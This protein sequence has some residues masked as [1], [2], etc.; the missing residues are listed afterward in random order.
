MKIILSDT[1]HS[2]IKAWQLYFKDCQ[3]VEIFAGSIFETGCNAIVSPANS[4]GFMDGGL[5]LAISNYLG[6]HVQAILQAKIKQKYHGELL[7]GQAEIVETGHPK[8]PYLISAPT[9]RVPLILN[10]TVNVY[11]AMRAVLL[12]I[13]YCKLDNGTPVKEVVRAVS[14]SG[15]GTGVGKVPADICARQMR[16]AY[17]EVIL[18]KVSFPSSWVDAQQKNQLLYTQQTRD[19]QYYQNLDWDKTE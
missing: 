13:K 10:T 17:D 16:V 11:L 12:L 5:D 3:D 6:W 19:L 4:F 9:M 7:V 15:L 18:D 1:N 14:I 8:I 2:V